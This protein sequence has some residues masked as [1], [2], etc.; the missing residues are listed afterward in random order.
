MGQQHTFAEHLD[1]FEIEQIKR[2]ALKK[3][4]SVLLLLKVNLQDDFQ[5]LFLQL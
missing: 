3:G 5:L 2:P 1:N 4:E